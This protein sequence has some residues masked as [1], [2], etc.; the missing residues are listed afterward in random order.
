MIVQVITLAVFSE[1]EGN[2]L[3]NALSKGGANVL[4]EEQIHLR[5]I[6]QH[7]T[8]SRKTRVREKLKSTFIDFFFYSYLEGGALE[9][10]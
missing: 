10:G 2:A 4:N 9:H 1:A 8:I 6:K 5:E 3:L 7:S